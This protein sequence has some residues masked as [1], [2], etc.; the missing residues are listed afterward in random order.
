MSCIWNGD[1]KLVRSGETGDNHNDR[2]GFV[3]Y[4]NITLVITVHKMLVDNC[5]KMFVDNCPWTTVYKMSCYIDTAQILYFSTRFHQHFN[6]STET[7]VRNSC[8]P[9]ALSTSLKT[10]LSPS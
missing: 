7:H 6:R 3:D 1:E 8:I 9:Y 5:H 10:Q 4:E 2:G